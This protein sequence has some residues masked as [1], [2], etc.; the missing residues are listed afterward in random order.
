M[1][2]EEINKVLEA[3]TEGPIVVSFDDSLQPLDHATARFVIQAAQHSSLTWG[4][5]YISLNAL[6]RCLRNLST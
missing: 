3:L 6:I 4:N 5:Y 2:T 1:T